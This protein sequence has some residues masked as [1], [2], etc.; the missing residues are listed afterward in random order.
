MPLCLLCSLCRFLLWLTSVNGVTDHTYVLADGVLGT[1]THAPQSPSPSASSLFPSASAGSPSSS[2]D[3][4]GRHK[5]KPVA[6]QP[7]KPQ[8]GTSGY[9]GDG[10]GVPRD[11]QATAA[12][13]ESASAREPPVECS[14]T[15]SWLATS[16]FPTVEGVLKTRHGPGPQGPS[17]LLVFVHTHGARA[18][19]GGSGGSAQGEPG[20]GAATDSSSSSR[21]PRHMPWMCFPEGPVQL[22]GAELL[23][24]QGAMEGL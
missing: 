21:C 3:P 13:A 12:G 5:H 8:D 18:T 24:L 16:A 11:P 6:G 9:S 17:R 1:G 23:D 14:S 20:A 2:W 4:V 22:L 10:S 7:S 15:A 19:V